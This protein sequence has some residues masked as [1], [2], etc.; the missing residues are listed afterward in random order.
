MP[1]TKKRTARQ[2]RIW[3]VAFASVFVA[4]YFLYALLRIQM[5]LVYQAR[6]PVFFLD[7]RFV[8]DFLTYPGGINELCSRFYLEF[9]YYPWTGA[10]A[11]T[12]LFGAVAWIFRQLIQSLHPRG[13]FPYLYWVPSILLIALHSDYT[14]PVVLS[15]GVL[16]VLLGVFVYVRLAFLHP[17][18]RAGLFCLLQA[19][20]YYVTVG[21]A[22]LFTLTVLGYELLRHRRVGL[23]LFYAAFAAILP[24]IGVSTIF[25]MHL[26]HAYTTNLV[27]SGKYVLG[28]VNWAL[29]ACVP[30]LPLLGG[31]RPPSKFAAS[32]F[33]S[34]MVR[35]IPGVVLVAIAVTVAIH[36]YDKPTKRVLLVDYYAR[37]QDWKN[38]LAIAGQAA[39]N[40]D[41]VQ[42]QAN[43]A[44]YHCDLLCDEMF[45]FVQHPRTKNLFLKENAAVLLPLQASDVFL[46]LG[47]VNEAQH[48]A[49]EATSIKGETPWVL[50][51]LVEVNLLKGER[52]V[53]AKYL[54]RLDK[55]LWLRGW[56]KEHRKFLADPNAILADPRLARIKAGM[57][58]T[59]F[60][61]PLSNSELCLALMLE[62]PG[63]RMVFE[64]Y[65]AKCLMEYDLVKFMAA[66]PRLTGLGY[67][68]IPRHFEEAI[69]VCRQLTGPRNIVPSGLQVSEETKQRFSDFNRILTKYNLDR[70]AARHELLPYRN[71]YWFYAQYYYTAGRS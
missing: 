21:Q 50:Q 51:R 13:S 6:E 44:L 49:H 25:A 19:T 29:Y 46:D 16:W 28:W 22:L 57:P 60:I 40:P 68:R 55:T 30:L 37:R 52:V 58:T 38:V 62:N 2:D 70:V 63:N 56:A 3:P 11:M 31:L 64:Y 61:V 66:L 43:R 15:L 27:L 34:I 65:M 48:W 26:P 33:G 32:G 7:W 23:A 69:C 36:S 5:Q 24:Y 71:T 9:Y 4:F 67:D 17:M 53:A 35:V 39:A 14:Y 20:L 1:K 45:D 47:L 41:Y 8:R 54:K 59:D 12:L 42:C 10:V 18:G